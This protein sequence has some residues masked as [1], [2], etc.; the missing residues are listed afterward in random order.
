MAV[1]L[2]RGTFSRALIMGILLYISL[3]VGENMF[4]FTMCIL[5]A[6]L[7]AHHWK[8]SWLL[9]SKKKKQYS[10]QEIKVVKMITVAKWKPEFLN[11]NTSF[12][13][14]SLS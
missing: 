8:C 7:D 13:L 6:A 5:T 9:G 11:V 12:L 2:V 4:N 1:R 14:S 3:I 10:E